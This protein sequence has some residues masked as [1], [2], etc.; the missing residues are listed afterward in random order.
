MDITKCYKILSK[1]IKKPFQKIPD[2]FIKPYTIQTLYLSNR[3]IMI[4]WEE[5]IFQNMED[6]IL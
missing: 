4:L 5:T 3:V 6:L 2:V 1:N